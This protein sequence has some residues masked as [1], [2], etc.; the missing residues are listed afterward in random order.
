MANKAIVLITGGNTGLGYETVKS[1]YAES[2]I[3]YTILMGSRSLSKAEDAISKLKSKVPESKSEVLPLQLDISSDESILA[4]YQYVSSKFGI[5][6][7]L[8]NNAGAS[9][10][11]LP[12]KKDDITAMRAAWNSTYDTNVTG[13]HILTHTFVPLILASNPNPNP[14]PS[15]SSPPTR[16]IL[17]L[18]SG[19]T[20]LTTSSS[21]TGIQLLNL[22]PTSPPPGWPKPVSPT[23]VPYRVAKT[24]LNMLMLHWRKLVQRDGVKVWGVSP[25]FLATALGGNAK[26]LKD[27]GGEDAAVGGRFVRGI[28]EGERDK[29]EGKIVKRDG[30]IQEW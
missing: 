26:F 3:P 19:S 6:D 23:F 17:F 2:E 13:T 21:P 20:S 11:P 7:V 18:T 24:G 22:D 15:S 1:L 12:D 9:I 27:A 8:I 14:K 10:D 30:T 4:A 29:D 28:V 25:G 16:R 5:I